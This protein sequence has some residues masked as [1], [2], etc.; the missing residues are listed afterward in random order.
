MIPAVAN[1][2]AAANG[3]DLR[4]ITI[5]GY[6]SAVG[7][8]ATVEIRALQDEAGELYLTLTNGSGLTLS[9]DGT[10]LSIAWQVTE[11]QIDTLRAALATDGRKQAHY[12]LKVTRADSV[13][14]QYLYGT[15]TIQRTATQ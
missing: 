3:Y 12:S 1:L 15:Y 8:S 4:T 11:A 9:S 6:A 7:V 14:L 2:S 13:T 10:D 5:P